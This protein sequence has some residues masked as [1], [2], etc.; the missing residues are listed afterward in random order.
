MKTVSVA[1]ELL[2]A[3]GVSASEVADVLR[4]L[5][6]VELCTGQVT[7]SARFG[8]KRFRELFGVAPPE[9]NEALALVVPGELTDSVKSMAVMP[10]PSACA[11]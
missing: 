10:K 9:G 11:E 4:E 6:A 7:I 2:P 3:S 1:V 8:R 5:G